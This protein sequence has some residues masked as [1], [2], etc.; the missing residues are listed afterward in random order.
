MYK[1]GGG[2]VGEDLSMPPRIYFHPGKYRKKN[3]STGTELPSAK[4][5]LLLRNCDSDTGS[6][7]L[8]PQC[9]HG[10]IGTTGSVPRA[11]GGEGQ[12]PRVLS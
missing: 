3:T 2:G 1:G 12:G 7:T 10:R 5:P 8:K 4:L 6:I 11:L 9:L